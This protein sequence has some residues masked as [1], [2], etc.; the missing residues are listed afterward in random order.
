MT[1]FFLSRWA[2]N[3][4]IRKISF[5]SNLVN[6]YTDK[7]LTIFCIVSLRIE[8]SLNFDKVTT[9]CYRSV[10]TF[11]ERKNEFTYKGG[12]CLV[13]VE[14][15]NLTKIFGKRTQTA[16][17]MMKSTNRKQEILQKPAQLSVYMKRVLMYKKVRSS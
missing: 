11:S 9:W 14:V 1:N 2:V 12:I 13:K 17:E 16:L 5:T 7:G 3:E 10:V 8:R 4:R 15:K 6:P